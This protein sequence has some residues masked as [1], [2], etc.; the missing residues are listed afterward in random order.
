MAE[1]VAGLMMIVQGF[2]VWTSLGGEAS[3]PPTARFLVWP[4]M[5]VAWHGGRRALELWKWRSYEL[6]YGDPEPT[7]AEIDRLLR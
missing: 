7:P 1:A 2:A 6:G 3:L 4:G 5:L